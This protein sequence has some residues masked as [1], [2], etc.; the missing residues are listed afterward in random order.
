M[1][2]ALNAT[3]ALAR[4]KFDELTHLV[5]LD[6]LQTFRLGDDAKRRRIEVPLGSLNKELSTIERELRVDAEVP[7]T[8]LAA[9]HIKFFREHLEPN[10][11]VLRR[12]YWECTGL[13]DLIESLDEYEPNHPCRSVKE[14]IAWGLERWGDMLDDDELEDWQSRGFA[15]DAAIEAIE[16]PWFE[17]DR[18]LENMLLLQPVLLDRPPQHVRDHIRYRL[19]EIYRAFTFGLWMS[20]IALC[21]SLLEYSL[22][23]TALQCGIERAKVGS[24]GELEDK[25]MKELSDEFSEQF[26]SLSIALEQVRDAGNRIMHAKKHDVVAYPK[27]LREDALGCIRSIR[28]SLETIYTRTS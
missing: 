9:S 22:K 13:R 11:R 28:Q 3:L 19:S 24:R 5:S 16:L 8:Q 18:W 12:A 10:A 1:N 15:I 23:D 20:S 6:E 2:N 26:P 7:V 17:P 25:S 27:V 21:R 4:Q 14:A